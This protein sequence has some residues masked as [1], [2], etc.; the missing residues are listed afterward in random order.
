LRSIEPGF[1]FFECYYKAKIN[2][3]NENF[4]KQKT[5]TPQDVPK[6]NNRIMR[7]L[8]KLNTT[9]AIMEIKQFWI[10]M[11]NPKCS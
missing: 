11:W 6:N 4:Q 2:P 5:S 7:A 1:A 10:A 8:K 3:A 9:L